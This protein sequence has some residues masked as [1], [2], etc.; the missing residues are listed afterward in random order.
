VVGTLRGGAGEG[1]TLLLRADMDALPIDEECA[2]EFISTQAGVMHACGH[3]A[4]VAI[5]LAVAERLA[6]TRGEWGGTVRYVFQPA[7]E[8]GGGALRMVEEGV[9]EGW[10]PRW[11]CTC[12]WGWRA[13]WWA[14]CR[15]RSW[16]RRG[17]SRSRCAG[18][19]ARR[20]P[21]MRRSTP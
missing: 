16:R 19:R 21:H 17:R 8:G 3:D 7:E 13:A 1:P 9:L 10:T 14:W 2:H 18:G 5:G 15:G 4:H 6:R 11:G 12:G 20:P